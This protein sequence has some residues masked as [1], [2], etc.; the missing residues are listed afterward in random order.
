MARATPTT[1]GAKT[2]GSMCSDRVTTETAT[3]GVG[4]AVI[5]YRAGDGGHRLGPRPG[6]DRDTTATPSRRTAAQPRAKASGLREGIWI[7]A[8]DGRGFVRGVH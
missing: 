5:G 2:A 1:A 8:P 7:L 6:R 3:E 4:V